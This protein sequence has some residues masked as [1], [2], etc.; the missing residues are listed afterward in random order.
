M[1]AFTLESVRTRTTWS[2]PDARV[3]GSGVDLD[4]FPLRTAEPRPW[5]GR[6]LGVGQIVRV[7]ERVNVLVTELGIPGAITPAAQEPRH[8]SHDCAPLC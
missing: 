5:R 4:D 8:Y 2:F 6:L 1:S 7:L 3:V